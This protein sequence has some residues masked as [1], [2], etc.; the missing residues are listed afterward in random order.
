MG[1]PLRLGGCV[2]GL[3]ESE[4]IAIEISSEKLVGCAP[5]I[6]SKLAKFEITKAA[7]DEVL[8]R[9]KV[10]RPLLEG[11]EI[12]PA[13]VLH[14]HQLELGLGELVEQIVE[15]QEGMVAGIDVAHHEGGELIFF[16]RRAAVEE[17]EAA[18]L[19]QL[20]EF[21]QHALVVRQMLDHAHDD[22]R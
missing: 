10:K 13:I 19:Q 4:A 11:E 2:L 6:K 5:E 22:D 18:G 21:L 7:L 1:S 14:L 17:H 20:I 12:A 3:V 9:L 15:H 16:P 8:V